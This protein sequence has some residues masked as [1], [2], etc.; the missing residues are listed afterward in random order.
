[1]WLVTNILDGFDLGYKLCVCVCQQ[2]YSQQILFYCLLYNCPYAK[3]F[4]LSRKIVW[5]TV[6]QNINT[7]G[8]RVIVI[9]CYVEFYSVFYKLCVFSHS[10]MSNSL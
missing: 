10:V 1:M 4:S 9:F 3:A 6:H 7:R 8:F 2:I 5:K